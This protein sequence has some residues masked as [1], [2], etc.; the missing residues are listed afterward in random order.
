MFCTLVGRY[1]TK[2]MS[3][4]QTSECF[5]RRERGCIILIRHTHNE[6]LSQRRSHILGAR[7]WCGDGVAPLPIA[8]T[9]VD[10][11]AE[12]YRN[13]VTAGIPTLS[14]LP[15]ATAIAESDAFPRP[16][17]PTPSVAAS[18]SSVEFSMDGTPLPLQELLEEQERC[19][20]Q[21]I[22][23]PTV[24]SCDLSGC[25]SLSDVLVS[26]VLCERFVKLQQLR[27]AQC[28]RLGE[29]AFFSVAY[30]LHD[31]VLLDLAS[32]ALTN[33]CLEQISLHC[34]DLQTL[35][36][37]GCRRLTDG[38]YKHIARLK[39]LTTLDASSSRE[40]SDAALVPIAS[41]CQ[42]IT[43]LLVN[44]CPKVGGVGA[45]EWAASGFPR[46]AMLNVT[47]TAFDDATT[48]ALVAD[49]PRSALTSLNLSRTKVGDAALDTLLSKCPQLGSIF[50]AGCLGVSDTSLQS[51]AEH[52]RSSLLREVHLTGCGAI[53][54]EGLRKLAWGCP[55]LEVLAINHCEA[56][57]AAISEIAHGCSELRFL[58]ASGCSG[59][60]D[61]SLLALAECCKKLEH[62]DIRGS[63]N[64]SESAVSVLERRLPQCKVFVNGLLRNIW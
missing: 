49:G 10:A 45:I 57:D 40:L 54:D 32:C 7:M 15:V 24:L 6:E 27:L 36:L 50:V 16:P 4:N 23:A 64:V 1:E 17:S 8:S 58:Q 31:L 3:N 18:I 62:V 42:H 47:A 28:I 53:S 44:L 48:G 21:N 51:L 5:T 37:K 14:S 29:P 22:E 19:E 41:A 20:D 38:G 25:M 63:Q 9:L 26:E 60:G 43:T 12:G 13:R 34:L 11:P 46:L 52:G 30:Q 61:A 33:D 56:T 55:Q 59:V 35:I 39:S 2:T